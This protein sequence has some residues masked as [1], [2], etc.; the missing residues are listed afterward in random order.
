M[1]DGKSVCG[2]SFMFIMWDGK[3]VCGG[4]FMFIMWDGKSYF[5]LIHAV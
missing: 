2:G 5:K 4:S 3:R 1:W